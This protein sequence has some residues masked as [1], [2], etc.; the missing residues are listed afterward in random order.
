MKC[1]SFLENR[2]IHILRISVTICWMNELSE[3]YEIHF[4]YKLF[5]KLP[6]VS[7]QVIFWSNGGSRQ[8]LALG[9]DAT[10]ASRGQWCLCQFIQE[11][12]C[13]RVCARAHTLLYSISPK[14]ASPAVSVK[15]EW[16]AFSQYIYFSDGQL[17]SWSL[18]HK[19]PLARRGKPTVYWNELEFYINTFL[20]TFRNCGDCFLGKED[21]AS[22][23]LL[24]RASDPSLSPDRHHI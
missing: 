13:A 11:C 1:H 5:E 12:M 8:S 14:W 15:T 4:I 7:I 22:F 10:V 19:T 21:T 2:D 6:A 16:P 24:L 20:I 17:R 23:P 18:T 3:T 9:K